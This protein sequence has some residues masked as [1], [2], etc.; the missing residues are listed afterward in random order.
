MQA[1]LLLANCTAHDLDRSKLLAKLIIFF[2]P[3]NMTSN[4]QSPD[5]GMIA[6][7][8]VGYKM[9]LLEK[10][11]AI[12]EEEGGYEAAGEAHKMHKAGCKGLDYG[13]KAHILD[14]LTIS[15]GLWNKDDTYA[16]EGSIMRCWRKAGILPVSWDCDINNAVSRASVYAK[17]KA[18]DAETCE[19]LCSLMKGLRV[20]AVATH[21]DAEREAY[22][23]EGSFAALGNDY[24]DE[25]LKVMAQYWIDVEDDP[26]IIDAD[27]D[28]ALQVLE[29]V[30]LILGHDLQVLENVELTE[31]ENDVGE[32]H[33]LMAVDNKEVLPAVICF[34]EA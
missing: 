22:A 27:I 21:A 11:L 12:F 16:K 13:G 10:L 32:S 14:A 28:K 1:L 31:D 25:Q 9:R 33:N 4:H 8:K 20:K 7:L 18:L 19:K 15:F 24:T 29:N 17:D 6:S 3:P 30:E 23:L 5:M 34:L 26:D 2:L